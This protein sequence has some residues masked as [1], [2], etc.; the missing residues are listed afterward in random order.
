MQTASAKRVREIVQIMSAAGITVETLPA[1]EELASGKVRASRVRP[2]EIT[3]LLGR[4]K[5]DLEAEAIRDLIEGKVVMVTGAGGSIGRELC[6]QIT[7][8]N[9]RRLLLVEQSEGSLFYIERE[10]FQQVA[11]GRSSCHWWRTFSI[12]RGCDRS[13]SN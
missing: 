10:S 7:S 11:K 6:R 2:V 13:L 1:I 4:D 5:V 12:S 3:D 9:P 8:L